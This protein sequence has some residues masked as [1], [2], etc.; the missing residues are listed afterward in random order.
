MTSARLREHVER[1]LARLVALGRRDL[2][3]AFLALD[4]ADEIPRL[5]GYLA[6]C[7]E[8][9][10]RARDEGADEL[11]LLLRYFVGRTLAYPL[12]RPKEALPP[13]VDLVAELAAGPRRGGLLQ[14]LAE[15][16]LLRAWHKVDAPGHR[17]A[18]FAGAKALWP[19]LGDDLGPQTELLDVVSRT[20]WWCRDPEL[21]REARRLAVGAAGA[22]RFSASF[23]Q[24]RELALDGRP[25]EA[26]ALL[27]GLLESKSELEAAGESWRHYLEVE[28]AAIEAGLG[29]AAGAAARLDRVVAG[30]GSTRDPML[31]WD[32][33]RAR[34]AVARAKG[35]ESGQL[36][37]WSDA[38]AVV[39]GL[40]TD[41]LECEFALELAAVATRRGDGAALAK[42]RARLD[43]TLPT[44][45]SA[46]D[47]RAA[48]AKIPGLCS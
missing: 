41:R 26:A 14:R 33:A 25:A 7:R 24:A 9:E 44:L 27:R 46:A 16:E 37:A 2:A 8:L 11:A 36:A 40:G 35:D 47:L 38:L 3:L 10:R 4:H 6:A 21:M 15:L 31:L 20:G 45:R 39:D 28:L 13:L 17:D 19:R 1:E 12:D 43:A 22:L 34:A 30:I 23:W 5:D 29:E 48:A 42:A 18:I 32:V